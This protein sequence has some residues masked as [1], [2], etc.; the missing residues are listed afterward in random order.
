MKK[1]LLFLLVVCAG[2]IL[3]Y[4]W[5]LKAVGAPSDAE[6]KVPMMVRIEEGA[7]VAEIADLL[8]EKDLIRSSLALRLYTRFHGMQADL[9][10]GKFV[11]SR[12]MTVPEIVEVLRTG[13][14]Q[15]V[16]VTIPEGAT[17]LDIE[18]LLVEK[19]VT[20]S[21]SLVSC[22]QTCDF[23][24]FEFLP[25]AE[26]LAARGGKLEGYLFPDTYYVDAGDFVSKFFLERLLTTFR[27]RVLDPYG[28]EI[29]KSERS[30]QDLM[31]MASLVEEETRTEEERP[32]VAGILWKR[33]DEG[34]G[35]GVDA[36]VRYI[37]DKPTGALT[38]SDLNVASPYNTRKFRGL[39]PGPIANPGLQS[40]LA[41]LRPSS[42]KYWYYLHDKKGVVHYAETNEEHNLNRMR[43]L[44]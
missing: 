22:A 8:G 11:F 34:M 3:W 41:A 23:S 36:T 28:E 26:G 43:Y 27:H 25:Q 6:K 21:G 40:I 7:S 30:L 12:T 44:Q 35:L 42:S 2:A 1:F 38:V 20:E 31:T 32:I 13:K 16:I 18:R 14:S 39:P 24:S 19:G 17:L 37:L 5:E 15:Q 4:K 10:A 33:H 9:K 29:Q